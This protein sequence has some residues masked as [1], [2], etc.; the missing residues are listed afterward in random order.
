[1]VNK[2]FL[3]LKK[4]INYFLYKLID[5]LNVKKILYNELQKIDKETQTELTSE[6]LENLIK[7]E[8]E[9]KIIN[10]NPENYKW[11]II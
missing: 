10:S 5:L 9:I 7:L 6:N 1:M 2:Y 3:K 4:R 8:N 11:V